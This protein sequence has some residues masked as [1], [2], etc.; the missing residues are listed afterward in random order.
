MKYEFIKQHSSIHR[1]EK[2]C[3]VFDV[4]PSSYYSWRM[5]PES[6]RKRSNFALLLQIRI[7]HKKS[8]CTYGSPRITASLHR[9]GEICGKN[10]VA[11]LMRENNIRSKMHRKF[12]ATTNSKHNLPVSPNLLCQNFSAQGPNRVWVSDISYVP[13]NQGWLYLA[14]VVDLFSRQIVGWATSERITKDLV[15]QAFLKAMWHRKPGKG[16]IFHSDRGSQYASLAFQ[17]LLRDWGCLGSMS[18]K[19]DCFDNACA[20]SFFHTLKTEL[21][22][23]ENYRTREEARRNIFEYIEVFYNRIRLHSTLGFYSPADFENLE[24]NLRKAA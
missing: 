11:R 9:R 12:K 19:G 20:E 14:V 23:F 10:R 13:T 4:A 24:E 15:I 7:L 8:H 18:K 3:H 1:I 17:K 21:V 5:R 2:M 22:Y 16:L 6:N